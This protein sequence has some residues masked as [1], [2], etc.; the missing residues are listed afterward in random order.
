MHSTHKT[1]HQ[2]KSVPFNRRELDA[3]I[4]HQAATPIPVQDD[5]GPTL[6]DLQSLKD[7]M[8]DRKQANVRKKLTNAMVVV[9][10]HVH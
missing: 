5:E 4:A 2:P 6:Q 1:N 10:T 8:K 9:S 3:I 7:T